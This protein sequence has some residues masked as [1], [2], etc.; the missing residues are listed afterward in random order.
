MLPA[1]WA[2]AQQQ[3]DRP[4]ERVQLPLI[5][6][7]VR[8]GGQPVA[9]P[10]FMQERVARANEIFAPYGVSFT[11]IAQRELDETHARLER[12]Q[13]RD[14]LGAW[15]QR[16]AIHCFVVESLRDVDEPERMRRGVHWHSRSYPGRHFV[17][18][19]ILGAADVFAHELGHYLG[20]PEHS[21]TPGNLMSYQRGDGLPFLDEQQ[22]SRVQR[23]LRRYRKSGELRPVPVAASAQR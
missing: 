10:E 1:R 15:V 7:T 8:V 12:R 16:G 14:A 4:R 23:A 13:D 11:I 6:H 5:V 22:V 17:I 2:Q 9:G 20:N 18:V 3:P 21:D 19:S